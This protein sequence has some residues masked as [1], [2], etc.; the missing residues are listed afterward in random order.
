MEPISL[1]V[2]ALTA[3]NV[4]STKALGKI[5][6]TFGQKIVEQVGK[7]KQLLQRKSPETA[8]AIETVTQQP[9]LAEVNPSEYGA[10]ALAERLEKIAGADPEIAEAITSLANTVN[11]QPQSVQQNITNIADNVGVNALDST[12]NNSTFNNT[13]NN[14]TNHI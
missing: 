5:G 6:E 11:I 2:A 4:L 3:V 1:S 9:E 8:S 7:L 10:K 12:F 14:T 13:T